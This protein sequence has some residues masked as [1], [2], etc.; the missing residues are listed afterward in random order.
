M[1]NVSTFSLVAYDPT[2][3]AWGIAVASKFPAVGAVVPWAEAGAGAVATQSFA[4]TTFGPRGLTFMRS[5]DSAQT[6]LKRLLDQDPHAAQRQIGMVDTHGAPATFTGDECFPWAGGRIGE[7]YAMQGNLLTGPETLEAME[8]VFLSSRA[9]FP[10]KLL[11]AL[12]AGD[13]AGG[14]KRG[15][16]SAALYIVKPEGGYGGFNDRWIDYRVD[17]HPDPIPQLASLL[18]LHQLYFGKSGPEDELP[19][20]GETVDGLLRI[21]QKLGYLPQDHQRYD[22]KARTALTAMIGNENFEDRTD[23]EKGVIDRPV[24]KFLMEKYA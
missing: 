8:T 2:C 18:Q 6:A 19:L 9:E 16:Q 4:N 22:Q 13:R 7:H 17:D 20:E 10:E 12:L 24:F 5:G 1:P 3:G 14:D 21:L 11:A 23:L 15:R